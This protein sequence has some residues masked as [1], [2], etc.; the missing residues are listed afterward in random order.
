MQFKVTPAPLLNKEMPRN[1]CSVTVHEHRWLQVLNCDKI[2]A[3]LPTSKEN[4]HMLMLVLWNSC[5]YIALW[6]I[7]PT[8]LP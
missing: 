2:K 5:A 8:S 7:F 1:R 6:H 3:S 4:K